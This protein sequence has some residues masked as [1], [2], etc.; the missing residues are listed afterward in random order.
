MC[1]VAKYR[2]RAI[3]AVAGLIA[4]PWLLLI[5]TSPAQ[6]RSHVKI[7]WGVNRNYWQAFKTRVPLARAVRIYY[8]TE[9]VFP[10]TWPRRAGS[11]VWVTLSIRPNPADL[12]SGKLDTQ[13]KALIHSAPAHSELTIWHENYPGDPLGYPRSV[14]NAHTA[15]AMQEHVEKLCKGTRVRFGV[16]ISGPA[17]QEIAWIAPKLDWYGVDLYDNKRYWNRDRTLSKQKIWARMTNNL[18]AFKKA[19][20]ERHPLIR[21]DE[22][23]TPWDNHRRNWFMWTAQ[24]FASHDGNRPAR[25]MTYWNA[26]HGHASGGL[27][28]PWPPSRPVVRVLRH[29][30]KT[31][32]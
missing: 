27:S 25:I 2:R 10:A 32:R 13:L 28:G 26:R 19:S 11:G 15:V 21:L 17:G 1:A 31:F 9:N 18:I 29:L 3:H 22:T 14:N 24:W 5:T 7:V 6:A 4:L 20:H 12:L 30:S 23:N 16:I 8:D